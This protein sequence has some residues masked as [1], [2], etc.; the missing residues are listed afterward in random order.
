MRDYDVF[1]TLNTVTN[2]LRL[3][4]NHPEVIYTIQS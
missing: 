1:N 3:V 4:I 2:S